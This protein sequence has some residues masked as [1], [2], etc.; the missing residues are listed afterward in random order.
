MRILAST[1][2]P[3]IIGYR[4]AFFDENSQEFCVVT[5]FAEGGD[6]FQIIRKHKKAR[7][8]IPEMAI[9]N[10]LEQISRGL[11]AL[12]DINIIHRDIKAANILLNK[13]RTIA[14]L[15]DM[16]VSKLAK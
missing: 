7:K 14:K 1:N 16:N 9:W 13:E 10:Y 6:L 3:N 4:D 11:K 8:Y 12:H 5:E 15:A 2:S